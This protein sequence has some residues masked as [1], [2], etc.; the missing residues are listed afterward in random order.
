MNDKSDILIILDLDE[1]L[2]YA[3]EYKLEIAEDFM[4]DKYFV[5]RRPGLDSFLRQIS[6][7]F[8]IGIWSS[9]GDTYVT[10]IVKTIKPA[11]VDF[12]IIWARSK[13][14]QRRDMELDL[15]YW[16][17]RLDKLKKKGFRIEKI[18]IVDDS[19][20]KAKNNFGNAIYIKEFKGDTADKELVT[21]HDYL[22]TLKHVDNVRTIE[23][24]NWRE[25]TAHNTVFASSGVDA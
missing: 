8:K 10:E 19:P 2:V 22:S 25:K 5:Y 14:T 7:H 12:E 11:D 1:T 3:T 6:Q 9:A 20:E 16:E 13:C 23:K 17:K 18:I 21:L 24:R 15:Y 4:F